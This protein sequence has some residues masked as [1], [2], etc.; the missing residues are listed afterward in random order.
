MHKL[1]AGRDPVKDL[2]LA[3]QPTLSRF[4]NRVS[5]RT[6][7][8]MGRSL[9]ESVVTRHSKRRNH[10]ARLVTIDLDPADTAKLH[11]AR[12]S[13]SSTFAA[14][15]SAAAILIRSKGYVRAFP[16]EPQSKRFRW[17]PVVL[18]FGLGQE[19]LGRV[20]NFCFRSF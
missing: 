7:Y 2:D 15:F 4:E 9:A 19:F 8:R 10:H 16:P 14:P 13:T 12:G 17:A 11:F 20:R 5:A 1:L 3:S 6:L 18:L